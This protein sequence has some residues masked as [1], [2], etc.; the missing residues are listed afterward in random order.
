MASQT[1][2]CPADGGCEF[3]SR[4]IS[5]CRM[6]K[7]CARSFLEAR[8]LGWCSE[9][10]LRR[11][12]KNETF[13]RPSRLPPCSTL[14][15]ASPRAGK[16]TALRVRAGI[17][18]S[19]APPGGFWCSV[20]PLLLTKSN[21]FRLTLDPLSSTKGRRRPKS[22]TRSTLNPRSGKRSSVGGNPASDDP[23]CPAIRR[24]VRNGVVLRGVVL[25]IWGSPAMCP[26]SA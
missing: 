22:R 23:G 3:L 24:G 26:P 12:T 10:D 5:P 19:F 17:W 16:P 6:Q 2:D 15:R 13:H 14:T 11:Y 25:P 1:L 18:C 4:L 8:V 20:A 21:Q 7:A 9:V